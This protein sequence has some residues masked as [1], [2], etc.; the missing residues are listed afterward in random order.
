MFIL[1][2]LFV[3]FPQIWML[4]TAFK[5][6]SKTFSVFWCFDAF[7]FENIINVTSDTR[8]IRYLLNSFLVA[9]SSSALATC[10]TAF[11]AF[12]F[13]KFRFW[14][15]KPFLS[16]IMI[17]QAFPSAVLLLSI[18]FMM[19][20]LGLLDN[21][22]SLVLAYTT[23]TLPVGTYTMKSFFDQV[24]DAI[25]ESGRIDGAST[26]T[27]MFRLV[28]PIAFPGII[29]IAINAFVWAWN[30]LLYS[31]TLITSSAK[32]TLAPGLV[33]TY[34]GEFQSNWG[35]MMSASI[36]V[37]IPVAVIFLM[38]QKYFVAGLTSGAVKG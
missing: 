8:M 19:R 37:S 3:L 20:S 2:G 26:P 29:S 1:L 13:S 4:N 23:F 24:P 36:V 25:I 34:L 35:E 15:R 18:Y 27:I 31:L 7:T 11:A 9:F 22:L 21:Y 33:L 32:R 38:L 30:D 5:E 28:F 10:V 16:M 17:S 14:L 12:S 6:Q